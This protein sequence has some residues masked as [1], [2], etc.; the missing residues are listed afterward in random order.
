MG[1]CAGVRGLALGLNVSSCRRG[2]REN[3]A[4]AVSCIRAREGG[5][6]IFVVNE[7]SLNSLASRLDVECSSSDSF[8]SGDA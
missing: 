3:K 8:N 2:T 6:T 1:A 7:V 5:G 4:G